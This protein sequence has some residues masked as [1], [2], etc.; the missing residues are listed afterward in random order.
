MIVG[1]TGGIA[2]GKSTVASILGQLGATVID[3][4][5]V[6]RDVVSAGSAGLHRIHARFGGMVLNKDGTLNRDAL[7]KHV[8]SDAK[9]RAA[10]E[11]IT[12][13]LILA[14]VSARVQAAVSKGAPAVFVEAALLVETGSAA[15]YAHLWVVTCDASL[16]RKRLM[17]RKGC[18]QSTA[19]R[20]IQSQMPIDEKAKHASRVIDNSGDLVSLQ[21]QVELAY[22]LL[23][24]QQP[25]RG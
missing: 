18:D 9:E 8:M 12:H 14:E 7:G 22:R 13:P 11:A 19:E 3:A 24:E 15:N 16:Q 1:L 10:L 20:W 25:G 6:S 5:L 17:T 4:D 21:E 23:M 2:T